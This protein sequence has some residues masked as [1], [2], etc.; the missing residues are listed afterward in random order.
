MPIS[1]N[2][3]LLFDDTEDIVRWNFFTEYLIIYI[4]QVIYINC[5]SD[6]ISYKLHQI[7]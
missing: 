3:Y 4:Y 1:K 5:I 7:V 2:N 6:K